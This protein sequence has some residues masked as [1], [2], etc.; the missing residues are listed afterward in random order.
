MRRVRVDLRVT[1]QEWWVTL[2]QMLVHHPRTE[3]SGRTCYIP[4]LLATYLIMQRLYLEYPDQTSKAVGRSVA[5]AEIGM[6]SSRTQLLKLRREGEV[7]LPL[8]GRGQSGLHAVAWLRGVSTA[9][10]FPTLQTATNPQH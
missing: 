9:R 2:V 4:E 7:S 1:R 5:L 3:N 8:V 10:P 6:Q